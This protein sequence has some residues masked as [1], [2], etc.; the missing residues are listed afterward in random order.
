MRARKLGNGRVWDKRAGMVKISSK[1]WALDE[2][3]S[4]LNIAS[5]LF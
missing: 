5:A 2:I 4:D 3:A 1:A